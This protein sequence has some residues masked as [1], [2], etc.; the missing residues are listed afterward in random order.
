MTTYNKATLAT[1]FQTGDVPDGTDYANLIDSQVN[2]VESSVQAM[3]GALST[4]ELITARV[5]ATN[6]NVTGILSANNLAVNSLT[7][8]TLA[9]TTITGSAAT[10]TGSV[11]ASLF[12]GN[13][14]SI[15]V[16]VSA[17]G[18]IYANANRSSFNYHG[19]VTIVSAAGTTQGTGTVIAIEFAR[20]QGVTDG[21]ATGFRLLSNQTGWVQYLANE[22]AA[23][24][25][26]WPPTGGKING[27]ANDAAFPMA[28]N[29]PYIVMHRAASAYSVK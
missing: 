29:V 20:L 24:A 17:G 2:I 22:C 15:A 21:S 14:L 12:N 23:S 9:A 27:L 8:T 19:T 18:S 13:S 7:V 28:A 1:F 6:V 26:L 16:D 25:N 3:G 10:F 11:S 4:P 5:S